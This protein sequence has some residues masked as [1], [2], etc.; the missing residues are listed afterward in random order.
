MYYIIITLKLDLVVYNVMYLM[1]YALF[2]SSYLL[3][4]SIMWYKLEESNTTVPNT[5][6]PEK[7]HQLLSF[8]LADYLD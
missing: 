8:H 1:I 6:L 3:C 4:N 5:Y 2:L 7:W